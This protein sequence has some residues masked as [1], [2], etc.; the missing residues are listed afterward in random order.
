M[1]DDGDN[2]YE[3]KMMRFLN[4]VMINY[5]KLSVYCTKKTKR[6]EK[7]EKSRYV[8]SVELNVNSVLDDV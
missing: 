6:Q 3:D 1:T 4:R 8:F 5:C 7:K 2:K